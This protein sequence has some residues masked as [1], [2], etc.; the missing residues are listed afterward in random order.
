M[1]EHEW[2]EE[3]LAAYLSGALSVEEQM[4]FEAHRAS[5]IECAKEFEAISETEKT[6]T[7]LFAPI[8]PG[9]EF[10]DR[11]IA[12]LRLRGPRLRIHPIVRRV[13]VAAAAAIVLG[14]FGYVASRQIENGGLDPI[15]F[16][17]NLRQIGHA[18]QLYSNSAGQWSFGGGSSTTLNWN[19]WR[20]E[21]DDGRAA[22]DWV[23]GRRALTLDVNGKDGNGQNV[24][25]GDGHIEYQQNPFSGVARDM[26]H[27]IVARNPSSA[28]NLGKT[29]TADDST[30]AP[31]N[32]NAPVAS[33]KPADKDGDGIADSGLPVSK[34]SSPYASFYAGSRMSDQKDQEKPITESDSSRSRL[35][36][37]NR[38]GVEEHIARE[39]YYKP[40]DANKTPALSPAPTGGTIMLGDNFSLAA[41][42]KK[43]DA[44]IG[45][46]SSDAPAAMAAPAQPAT[47]PPDASQN[48]TPADAAPQ[49]T[50]QP[51]EHKIIRNGQI[52][53]EVDSFDSATLAIAKI[54]I[55]EHGYV[56]TTN[57]AKL[58]NGKVKG[59]IVV[60]VTP[61]HLDTLVLKLRALGD[62]K[63]Q[64]LTA[65]DVTKQYTD[66]ASELRAAQAM[67]ERLLSIIKSSQGQI[68]DLLAAEKE[69]ATWREKI[70][71]LEGEIRY[72]DNLVAMSTLNISVFERDIKTA[73]STKESENVDMGVEADDVET[74]RANAIK[75]I[76]DAK[77]RIVQSEMK[78]LDAGQLEAKVIADIPPENAGPAIDRL[79]QLGQVARFESTR[80]QTTANGEPPLAGAKLE[81]GDM[82]VQ[83]SLYNLANVAPRQT[84]NLNLAA[85][86]V[87]QAYHAIVSRVLQA[88]GRIVTSN[89]NR[90]TDQQTGGVIQ[91][92]VKSADADAA[93]GYSQDRRSDSPDDRGESR[94]EQRDHRQA[95]VQCADR[96]PRLDAAARGEQSHAGGGRCRCIVQGIT[97]CLA[98]AERADHRLQHRRCRPGKSQRRHRF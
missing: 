2:F 32:E 84:D 21:Q 25:Y 98:Q 80:S 79:R 30:L 69:L 56:A 24:L 70:E 44:G 17:T 68:K 81:R 52:E 39:H 26:R 87:E 85:E 10:E 92:E 42:Q 54:V 91:F 74:A 6:M 61:D 37:G 15:K 4:R 29:I 78:K 94:H 41:D 77:G 62:L 27:R 95:R 60:R 8:A 43:Q 88:G 5:C 50:T 36:E 38:L 67:Q 11:L 93:V 51:I 76:E 49:P 64:H 86:D 22:K 73:A 96:Q 63:S 59:T 40:A 12:R 31:T 19:N 14:G 23:L 45:G 90:Q 33:P 83:L 71:K 53:F 89:L 55:E 75:A 65:Q 1:N 34:S 16:A 46:Q 66:T 35:V 57:S 48:T 3:Q 18:T 28:S 13:A 58:P 97:R 82:H 72:Y 7:Q 20:N 9:L 47:P